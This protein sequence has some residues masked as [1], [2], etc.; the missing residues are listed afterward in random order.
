MLESKKASHRPRLRLRFLAF[1]AAVSMAAALGVAGPVNTARA[2]V[3]FQINS[4]LFVGAADAN[5][6]NGICA[7]A[8]GV[9]TLRA[10]LEEANALGGNA[11][12][13]VADGTS[14]TIVSNC[15]AANWMESATVG[16]STV[17]AYYAIRQPNIT[18]DL[19]SRI[20]MQTTDCNVAALYVNG[21]NAV[22]QNIT[23]FYSGS[24]IMQVGGSG[25]GATFTNMDLGAGNDYFPERGVVLNTGANNVTVQN[26][27]FSGQYNAVL[28]SG[29]ITTN[30]GATVS[31]LRVTGN[32]F[33]N[34]TGTGTVCSTTSAKGCRS[35]G[36]TA[37]PG[38]TL[39]GLRIDNNV[40]T[41][42]NTNAG[43]YLYRTPIRFQ[44]SGAITLSNVDIEGNQFTGQATSQCD[45]CAT[46]T[47][48]LDRSLGGTNYIRNNTFVA[49]T[50]TYASGTAIYWN[51]NRAD[52]SDSRLTI[53][54]N[55]FDGFGT[56]NFPTVRLFE[57][58]TVTV[59]RN[60]FGPA[61]LASAVT[62]LTADE[63]TSNVLFN[64]YSILSNRKIGTWYPT[65]ATVLND[66]TCQATVTVTPPV[67]TTYDKPTLPARVDVY[68][69]SSASGSLL[70]G[71]EVLLG[72]ITVTTATP[73]TF[74]FA[75]NDSAGGNVRVQTQGSNPWGG[76]QSPSSQYSRVL[77][78]PQG[79]CGPQITVNQAADQADPTS[80]R[81]VRFTVTTSAPLA[82][83]GAGALTASDF[84]TAGSTAPGVQVVSVTKINDTTY[85]VVARANDTG[86]IA[87]SLP[88]GAVTDAQGRPSSPSTSTDNQ[89]T[90]VNPLSLSPATLTVYQ[91]QP[92]K[93]VTITRAPDI[94]P[95]A[96]IQVTSS[97][98]NGWVAASNATLAPGSTTGTV[99]VTSN[100]LLGAQR[101]SVVTFTVTSADP[102]FDG[103]LL[104]A[105]AVTAKRIALSVQKQAWSDAAHTVPIASNSVVSNG[106]QVY[107]TYTVTNE[108]DDDLTGVNVTDDALPG[109]IV[110]SNQTIPRLGSV[111]C[112]ASAAIAPRAP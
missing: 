104:P 85:A 42:F 75:Y 69:N 49:G 14:G 68:F 22:V 63:G 44:D 86:V 35:V 57:T 11:L 25:A 23:S 81:A 95:T 65:A 40:F 5:P 58:G 43:V 62:G 102:N 111:E 77:A 20:Y 41:N 98:D 34:D 82:T 59:E 6:G 16:D 54:N 3:V 105:V 76:T 84:S 70:Q 15:T 53:T 103:L 8:G 71:A 60:T 32:T 36:I 72:S 89:V 55:S 112:S 45:A 12:I 90:Y 91:G 67:S 74:T 92:G 46:I 28:Y 48:P 61:S 2:A 47:M 27:R 108:G 79:V 80:Q 10:A 1:I 33:T 110:C 107:W 64:N 101:N 18:L 109:G 99:T 9:C 38:T 66:G 4:L 7:T 87:L 73:Q 39:T 100:D 24:T 26:S 106:Q 78:I 50:G 52:N 88:Q 94:V 17:G 37:A 29:W 13:T 31:N 19:L 97:V 30:T 56:A 96:D 51:S 93:Q 21:A 83:T